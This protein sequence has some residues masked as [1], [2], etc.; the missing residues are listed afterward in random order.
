[1]LDSSFRWNDKAFKRYQY[2]IDIPSHRSDRT[3]H[4]PSFLTTILLCFTAWSA[5]VLFIRWAAQRWM[6]SGPAGTPAD[7]LVWH[8]VRL[9]VKLVHRA[10][11][12]NTAIVPQ[13]SKPGPLIVV[14]NH[15]GSIDALLLQAGCRFDIR[16]MMATDF[17]FQSL[18]WLW[19]WRRAI[20]VDRDGKDMAAAREA[21][22][23]V[24]S[25][26]II[27]LFPE[28]RIV[29]PPERVWPFADGIGLIVSRT[30]APVLLVWVS[31][32]PAT[33]DALKSLMTPSRSRVRFLEMIR[34]PDGAKPAEIA[35]TLR[36]KLAQAS[37]W[38]M[39][40]RD[41]EA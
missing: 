41:S 4:M 26:G 30:Q 10:T 2:P 11:Y 40:E 21:I 27:G 22:R 38:P 17:M 18:D 9:F 32:T 6:C 31:G 33:T 16:W 12:E 13:T 37:G 36:E 39:T 1:M 20:C 29:T 15:T 8:T 7:F 28:G 34:F 25:G 5:V 14:S 19:T 24:K 3:H 23:H 35:R